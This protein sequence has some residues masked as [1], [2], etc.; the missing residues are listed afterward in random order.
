MSTEIP[1]STIEIN[2]S[3]SL[4]C[5]V[6]NYYGLFQ[7]LKEWQYHFQILK[8]VQNQVHRVIVCGSTFRQFES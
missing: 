2:Y 5:R 3:I 8:D 6:V 1:F 4:F 7:L